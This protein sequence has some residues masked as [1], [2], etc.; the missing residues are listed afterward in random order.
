MNLKIFLRGLGLGI[1]LTAIIMTVASSGRRET[2]TNDE[3]KAKAKELGMIEDK[4]LA[5]YMAEFESKAAKEEIIS[6][7][8]PALKEEPAELENQD[9]V[10]D[11]DSIKTTDDLQL[12]E[13]MTKEDEEPTIFTVRKGELPNS[14]CDRLQETGLIFSADEFH[15]YLLDNGYDRK[16]VAKEYKIPADADDETIARII[17]GKKID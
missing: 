6:E 5:D 9:T 2:L 11:N 15:S 1:V 17:M 4:V 8:E 14:I 7:E 12:E 3:I 16:I 13:G 10:S